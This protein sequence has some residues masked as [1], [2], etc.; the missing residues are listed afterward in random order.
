MVADRSAPKKA[1][2]PNFALFADAAAPSGA[3]PPGYALIADRRQI[4]TNAWSK[5]AVYA[6]I[7]VAFLLHLL[8]LVP[9]LVRPAPNPADA[10]RELGMEEGAPEHLNVSVISEADLK[11]LSSDPFRQEAPPSPAP[12]D[13]PAPPPEPQA[14]PS[15]PNLP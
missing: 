14:A 11:R 13:N 6:A 5:R 4:L 15:L 10:V 12:T 8:V 7:A 1:P 2:P 3:T 9:F